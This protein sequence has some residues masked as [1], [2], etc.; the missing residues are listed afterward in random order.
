MTIAPFRRLSDPLTDR[1]RGR[2]SA[3]GVEFARGHVAWP[4]LARFADATAAVRFVRDAAEPIAARNEVARAC[5][6]LYQAT[7][8]TVWAH[9]L[10]AIFH[11]NLRRVTRQFERYERDIHELNQ[12]VLTA[13]LETCARLDVRDPRVRVFF[14]VSRGV[15]TRVQRALE[16]AHRHRR[17]HDTTLEFR[18]EVDNHTCRRGVVYEVELGADVTMFDPTVEPRLTQREGAMLAFLRV[19]LPANDLALLV[20]ARALPARGEAG[21]ER[22]KRQRSRLLARARALLHAHGRWD[23]LAPELCVPWLELE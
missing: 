2:R 17:T 5:V 10:L 7:R 18:D 11:P 15:H 6:S 19:H 8:H 16:R 9:G 4:C 12:L 1:V 23:D 3:E 13:L 22:A 20:R 21:Y 14:R